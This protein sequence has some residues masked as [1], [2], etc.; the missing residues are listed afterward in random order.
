M[1]SVGQLMLLI[2]AIGLFAAGGVLA[3]VRVLRGRAALAVPAEVCRWAG[4]GCG[5]AVIVWHSASRGSWLP[6]EDNF[7]TL[8]WLGLLLAVFAGYVQRRGSPRGLDWFVMPSAIALLGAAAVFGWTRPREYHVESLWHWVHRATS[9]GGAIAF[10]LAGGCGLLYL[11][12]SRRLRKKQPIAGEG[13][14]SLERLER[15]TFAS[16]TLGFAL[17]TI[18][19]VTGIFRA[20]HLD[21]TALGGDWFTSPK[22]LLAAAVWA[23]YALVMHAPLNPSFRGRR[24]AALS[25]LGFVLM[26]GAIVAV[27]FMPR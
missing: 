13:F 26:I 12:A 4:V 23:V 5:I 27:Q 8:V 1:P 20:V 7:D 24:S 19:L 2:I 3:A 11:I 6:L 16:V 21:R 10:A 9:Y 18:G 25:I 14:G 17:L 22:V 15:L